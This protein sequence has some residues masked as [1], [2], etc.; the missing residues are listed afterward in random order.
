MRRLRKNSS[1]LP[2][3]N[4]LTRLLQL[5][6]QMAPSHKAAPKRM[7]TALK[8][9][10]KPRI[11]VLMPAGHVVD[12]D[13][14]VTYT[15]GKPDESIRKFVNIGDLF[16][17]E[18]SLRILD[19]AEVVAV[20]FRA[21][22]KEYLEQ[23][24]DLDYL[25]LRGS[26]YIHPNG[27]WDPLIKLLKQTTVPVIAF[28]L[29]VQIADNATQEEQFVNAS[30]KLMLQMIADRSASIAVR[31][32]LS[33]KVLHT[34]GIKNVRV[35]GCPTV[36]RH[37]H[38]TLSVRRQPSSAIQDL[39]FTLRRN[40]FGHQTL[41]RYLMRTLS[42]QYRL[43]IFC[44]GELEEKQFFYARRNMVE[45]PDLVV[46]EAI[47]KLMEQNWIYGPADPLLELYERN[48]KV[49]E[50]VA[51]F[52]SEIRRM[53]AVIGFRLHGNLLALA[54]GI[55]ALYFT[56]DTRTREFVKALG[57]PSVD[58]RKM[59]KFSFEAAWDTADFDVFERAYVQR[60]AELQHFLEENHIPHRLGQV[61]VHDHSEDL[62]PA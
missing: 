45:S 38:P 23:I 29:G 46:E 6:S 2:T 34:I 32:D 19:Y 30:T 54:N 59:D 3:A 26:N 39:G 49:F 62:A 24:E 43:S 12:H 60:Y 52:E 56:Y 7:P 25:F 4:T 51:D 16:V 11:G 18:S 27:N 5:M 40:T 44:A 41:Q 31:G 9:G 35:I 61:D 36:F 53:S 28:G 20:P 48:L 1:P 10:R 22:A 13:S 55:P 50:S 21:P 42:E 47:A 17:F 37:R 57:I 33:K 15:A 8:E 58:A 14:A